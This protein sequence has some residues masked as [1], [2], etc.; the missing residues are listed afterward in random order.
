MHLALAGGVGGAKL[1]FG[2][3]GTL[4][5]ED[6]TIVV[7]T[8]DD[9]DH[10]GLRICPDLDTV[11]YTLAGIA[12]PETGWGV[13]DET[14][15]FMETL[16]RQGRETWFLLGDRDLE[17]HVTRTTRLAE[18]APLSNVTA[19]LC[20]KHGIAHAVLPMSDDRVATMVRSNEGLL[21]FQD[22]FVRRQCAPRVEGF[23]FVGAETARPAAAVANAFERGAVDSVIL[24][25]SN[26]YVSIGPI[27]AMP[28][29]RKRLANRACP[30]VA[31]SP[32]VEG[33]A[34]KGPAAKMMAE[35]GTDPSPF[36]VAEFYGDLLDGMVVDEA[37]ADLADELR[38]TGLNVLVTGT[39]MRSDADRKRLA[40][41][42]L[43]WLDD[44]R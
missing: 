33:T 20:A 34:L 28:S 35:L 43:D 1:A 13:R 3:A 23:E 41:E 12:N 36:S 16:R 18:G 7:N 8:G 15:N 37:D 17:T 19:E 25:P 4:P 6:L 9:F 26:P 14:W 31:V 40:A 21:A 27:L 42:T 38:D 24:C 22:Y 5:P 11:M 32:I 10:L 29:F 44:L 2:L 39:V 30:C